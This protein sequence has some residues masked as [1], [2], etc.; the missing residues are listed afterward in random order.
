MV[1]KSIIKK[2]YPSLKI[3]NYK[4]NVF[5]YRSKLSNRALIDIG[6]N[7]SRTNKLTKV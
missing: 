1:I 7:T 3:E 4:K 2:L 5:K 6:G